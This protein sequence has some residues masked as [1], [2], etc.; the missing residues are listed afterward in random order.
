MKPIPLL[1]TLMLTGPAWASR[2]PAPLDPC[3]AA[4]CNVDAAVG[5]V[6]IRTHSTEAQTVLNGI[7]DDAGFWQGAS[8][9]PYKKELYDEIRL[10]KSE[11]GY[12]PMI[13]GQ[14]DENFEGEVV[15]H[16]VYKRNTELPKHMS[17]AK[18]IKH[19]GAG[20]DSTVG[21]EYRDSLY[22]LDLTLFYGYFPQRMYYRYDESKQRYVM[23]FEK[24]DESWVDSTVWT[25]YQAKITQTLDNLDKRW[26]FN[27][28]IEVTDVFGMFVVTPGETMQSRVTFVS[29]LTFGDGSG[30]IAKAGSQMPSVIKAGLK[31][32]FD[33]CV[34]IAKDEQQKRNAAQ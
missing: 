20:Y 27:S 19:L 18:A 1:I 24:I 11:T 2:G 12:V 17:G 23:W 13:T 7:L 34:A 10:Q 32:G 15:A 33:A 29:K 14:G 5:A 8:Q 22:V 9:T 16:I 6:N 4:T 26:L 25:K 30:F 28:I 21:A 3:P 31:S